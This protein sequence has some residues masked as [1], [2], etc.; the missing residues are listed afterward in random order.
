M[1]R[2]RVIG[3]GTLA[4]LAGL[5]AAIPPT[6]V[7]RAQGQIFTVTNDLD[8]GEPGSLSDAIAQANENPGAETVDFNIP[9]AGPQ[10]VTL[11]DPLPNITDDLLIMGD[12]EPNRVT[13]V[14]TSHHPLLAFDPPPAVRS[15]SRSSA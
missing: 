2:M 5:F 13:L 1:P 4:L 6:Q 14:G 12:Q 9:G 11:Q 7:A 8:D 15:S 3:I 10:T